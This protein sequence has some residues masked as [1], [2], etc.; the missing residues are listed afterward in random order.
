MP[1]TQRATCTRQHLLK[2]PMP[3][4]PPARVLCDSGSRSSSAREAHRALR[5][6]LFLARALPFLPAARASHIHHGTAWL[7]PACWSG[8]VRSLQDRRRMIRPSGFDRIWAKRCQL[9]GEAPRLYNSLRSLQRVRTARPSSASED[10]ST[11]SPTSCSVYRKRPV[12]LPPLAHARTQVHI[13]AHTH[14]QPHRHT[15]AHT[16]PSQPPPPRRPPARPPALALACPRLV[17]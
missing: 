10:S 12:A 17:L 14:A 5:P 8:A 15:R 2:A 3:S 9:A 6:S 7:C 13:H 11:L 16:L 4:R 1:S